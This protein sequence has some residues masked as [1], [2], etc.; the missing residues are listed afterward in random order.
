MNGTLSD[1][2]E[3]ILISM[4]ERHKLLRTHE[5]LG[6]LQTI[7]C[8]Q[9]FICFTQQQPDKASQKFQNIIQSVFTK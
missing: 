1:E 6:K 9:C 7:N 2:S 8:S 5:G 4:S 3:E